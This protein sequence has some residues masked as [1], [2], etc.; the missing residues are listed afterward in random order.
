MPTFRERLK[1][2]FAILG[3]VVV[4]VLG[5]LLFRLWTMQILAGPAFAAR[6]DDNRIREVTT[7]APRGRILDRKGRELVTNRPTMAVLAARSVAENAEVMNKLSSLLDMPVAELKDR[8]TSVKEAALAPRVVA[9]DV[10][11]TTVAYLAEHESQFPGVEVATRSV[12]RYPYGDLAAHV[13]GYTGEIS[14]DQL[15]GA[16]FQGYDPTDVVGKSGAESSFESVL[17]G[18]RGLR[19]L[20]VDAAGRP[21]RIISETEPE[22]GRDVVLTID[23]DVQKVTEEALAQAI[24]DAH[25]DGYYKAKAGAA[26]AIDT[27]TGE[28]LAMASAPTYDPAVFLGGVSNK[29]WRSLTTTSSEFPLSNRAIQAQY[30]AASTFKAM[31]GLA[32]LNY[33]LTRQWATYTCRG[34]WTGMGKQWGKYCWNRSG[35][36]VETFMDGFADSCDTVFYEIGYAFYKDKGEKLQKFARSFGYGQLTGIDLGGE[37]T[38]RVPDAAWKKAYNQNY[39]E[40]QGWL[41]GDTV[42]MAIGQGDLLVTPLQVVASYAGIANNGKVMKPHVLRKVLGSDGKTVLGPTKE[43]AFAPKVSKKNLSI[44]GSALHNVTTIGTAKGA[45]RGFGIQ[46]AG[47]TGTAEVTGKDDYAWFVG[48]APVQQ[49]KYAVV[50]VL[51]QGGHGGSIAAPA[52][53]QI[54]AELLGQ[55]VEHVKAKDNSR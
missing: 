46:V 11:M 3:V 35:H 55:R 22:A 43:V 28:I 9:I 23:A 13:L 30:P 6:A 14:E 41:P 32:G 45:F 25:A 40:Y 7:V 24:K 18:D 10:P 39:P 38:G 5:I 17:Q 15:A 1:P 54:L 4:A 20:E 16:D 49:P 31:T 53:R 47:K 2:R 36:G 19:R 27:R 12:R 34:L 21:K 33:G 26:I 42:N 52:G 44:V 48:Y 51:E 37:A 29:E 8:I 50:V